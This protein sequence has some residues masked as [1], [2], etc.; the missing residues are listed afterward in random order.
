KFDSKLNNRKGRQLIEWFISNMNG[1][2]CNDFQMI[3]HNRTF[4]MWDS[5]EKEE[6]KT[7]EF[8]N[9]CA[10]LCGAVASKCLELI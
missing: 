8:K 3:C 6:L 5:I 4:D 1:F 2:S 10:H 9:N 7:P